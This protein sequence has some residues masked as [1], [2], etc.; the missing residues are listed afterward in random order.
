[1]KYKCI[2][3]IKGKGLLGRILPLYLK[4]QIITVE[5]YNKLPYNYKVDFIEDYSDESFEQQIER[6]RI[7][8]END[9]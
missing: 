8:D 7:K 2:T 4:G 6:N 9:N 1:M 5:Q 3:A